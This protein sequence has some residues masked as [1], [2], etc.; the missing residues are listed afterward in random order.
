VDKV[1]GSDD[2]H[3]ADVGSLPHDTVVQASQPRGTLLAKDPG[4]RDRKA[5]HRAKPDVLVHDAE[6]VR[7]PFR[8]HWLGVGLQV[9]ADVLGGQIVAVAAGAQS[10]AESVED[11]GRLQPPAAQ[12]G[13][14][15]LERCAQH[16]PVGVPHA[17]EGG[18]NDD[19]RREK[20]RMLDRDG[21]GDV[22]A[23]TPAD[24]G[25]RLPGDF[26]EDRRQVLSVDP[27]VANGL[28]PGLPVAAPVVY[29]DVV[30]TG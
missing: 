23:G 3:G 10:G 5:G 8:Q 19:Q 30:V 15:E 21:E 27:V 16:V 18:L 13:E 4:Q 7:V 11:L 29:D 20:L 12:L 28:V 24:H 6:G 2:P 26:L 17:V 1:P 9:A 22:A 14:F 25:G